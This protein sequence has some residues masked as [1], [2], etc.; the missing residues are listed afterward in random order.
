MQTY[1]EKQAIQQLA[2]LKYP[3]QGM[4]E[5]QGARVVLMAIFWSKKIQEEIPKVHCVR[6]PHVI[7]A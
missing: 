4:V 2:S 5:R 7:N 1:I 3:N 6:I